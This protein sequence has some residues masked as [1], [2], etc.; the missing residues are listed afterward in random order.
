MNTK[1]YEK[2]YEKVIRLG[3]ERYYKNQELSS[4]ISGYNDQIKERIELKR[5]ENSLWLHQRIKQRL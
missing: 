3:D 4:M 2:H 5:K 1:G